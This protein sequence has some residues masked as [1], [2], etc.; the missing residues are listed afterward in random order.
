MTAAMTRL[1]SESF[2]PTGLSDSSIISPLALPRGAS[3][4][5]DQVS[6]KPNLSTQVS[7]ASQ[8]PIRGKGVYSPLSP[9][10]RGPALPQLPQFLSPHL[11]PVG[12]EP[13]QHRSTSLPPT[14]RQ[15]NPGPN[16]A[17]TN[18]GPG[19]TPRA[20]AALGLMQGPAVNGTLAS[21]PMSSIPLPAGHPRAISADSVSS[22][23]QSQMIRRLIQQNGRIRE[24]WEAERKYMEA[25]RERAEEVY[26]EER[27]LMEEERTEWE[28]E[29]VQL[30]QEIERLQQ[31]VLS[32]GGNV[33]RPKS[34]SMAGSKGP[35]KPAQSL[36]GGGAWEAS[37]ES[38]RS[39]MSSQGL[40]NM[41]STGPLSQH[42]S[43]GPSN[44]AL[45]GL[46]PTPFRA[47]SLTELAVVPE[48][49]AGPVPI[50]DVQEI[51]PELEGIPIKASTIQKTTF[52]DSPSQ[53]ASKTS[54]RAS[55]P[56]GSTRPR[57]SSQDPKEQTLQVLAAEE[58]VRLTMHAGHT[59]SHSLSLLPTV[60]SSGAHTVRSSGESTP[61][62]ALQTD[63]PGGGLGLSIV[64][65]EATR[66]QVTVHQS[67]PETTADP[68][69]AYHNEPEPLF[70]P[71]EDRELKGPLMVR[72]MPAHDE[73]FFRR[74]S[75]KLEEVIKD[76]QAALPAVLKDMDEGDDAAHQAILDPHPEGISGAHADAQH[77]G[78]SSAASD[79]GTEKERSSPR[80][81]DGEELDIPL[82]FKRSINFG[83]PLGTFRV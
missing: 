19:P 77:D 1:P 74:L 16:R 81:S 35:F 31:H 5:F 23:S 37:P 42:Q 49:E 43:D 44:C 14:H 56:P 83:A 28:A 54:S 53:G 30:L 2:W 38:M 21:G 10:A 78:S 63:G 76:D 66:S 33:G 45:V 68:L 69:A 82:K 47:A 67:G 20:V 8:M 70:E 27:A 65:E 79:S 73:I 24:A 25:N 57:I 7:S 80:S 61:R 62:M 9:G 36:R 17:R 32:L 41:R 34:G 12:R 15:T 29:K 64:V 39:S 26:K 40:T 58:S 6:T 4:Y 50:V 22:P 51:H 46:E 72:N 71:S 3:G 75:D 11:V 48:T 52:T 13:P 18:T 55:S 59:P 60:S